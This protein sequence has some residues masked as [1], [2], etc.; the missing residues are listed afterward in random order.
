MSGTYFATFMEGDLAKACFIKSWKAVYRSRGR[1]RG[2]QAAWSFLPGR[3]LKGRKCRVVLPSGRA[4][5]L[6]APQ[7]EAPP[8]QSERGLE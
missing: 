2:L 8:P 7:V 1:Y 5:S 3:G 4:N 6:Q